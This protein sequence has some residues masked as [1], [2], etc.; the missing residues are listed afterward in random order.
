M[1]RITKEVCLFACFISFSVLF[2]CFISFSAYCERYFHLDLSCKSCIYIYILV[3]VIF[4]FVIT[5]MPPTE[6]GV[7]CIWCN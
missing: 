1:S 6:L 5:R 2:V 7:H 3:F 4:F